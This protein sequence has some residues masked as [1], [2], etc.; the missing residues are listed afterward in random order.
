M[1]TVVAAA[2][3][4]LPIA[5]KTS[6]IPARKPNREAFRKIKKKA[7]LAQMQKLLLVIAH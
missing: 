7:S 1:M 3:K 2:M 4:A 6:P 5:V